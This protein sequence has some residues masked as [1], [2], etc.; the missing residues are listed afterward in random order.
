MYFGQLAQQLHP[1]INIKG[2]YALI[3]QAETVDLFEKTLIG[4]FSCV[5]TRLAFDSIILLPKYSQ[6]QYKENLKAI[7]KEKKR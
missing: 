3:I 5:N 4:G 1:S 2:N 7:Y 6:G